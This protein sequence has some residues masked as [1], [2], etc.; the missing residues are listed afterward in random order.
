VGATIASADIVGIARHLADDVLY[1]TAVETDARSTVPK[2]LLD[3]LADAGLYGLTGPAGSGGLGAGFEITC[4]VVEELASGCLTTTFVWAQHIGVVRAVAESHNGGVRN[5]LAP[6]CKGEIRAG[7][8]LG[9]ALSGT[10][11]LRAK[12]DGE[13][14][15]IAGSAHFV[16]GWNRVD[17]IHA[18]AATEDGKLVWALIDAREGERLGAYHL[19]L[20]AL[21][22]THTVRLEFRDY[23]VSAERVTA[24]SPNQG[25][26][27]APQVLRMHAAFALGVAGRCGRLLRSPS[28]DEQLAQVR[29]KLD[30]LDPTTIEAARGSAGDLAMRSALALAVTTGSRSLLSRQHEELLVREALFVLV[31][32]LRPGSRAATLERLTR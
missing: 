32:A 31:Y 30:R 18:A 16:S 26:P 25:G 1:P 12:P 5:W 19:D 13:G 29:T 11:S 17:A 8:A 4:A 7:L 24:V 22:A 6:L 3:K 15:T 9:G 10:P 20:V 27:P 2:E 14:W 21:N 28:F 23:P